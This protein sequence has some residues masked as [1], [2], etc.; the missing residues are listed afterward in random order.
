MKL[1]HVVTREVERVWFGFNVGISILFTKWIFLDLGD[2]DNVRRK[3]KFIPYL[4]DPISNTWH[5][6]N[7]PKRQIYT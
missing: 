4:S 2:I 6:L 3:Y 7:T 5:N 1:F